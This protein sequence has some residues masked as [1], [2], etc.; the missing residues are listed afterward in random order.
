MV[1]SVFIARKP[2]ALAFSAEAQS[3]SRYS[4]NRPPAGCSEA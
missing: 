1:I 3:A 4:S 2:S